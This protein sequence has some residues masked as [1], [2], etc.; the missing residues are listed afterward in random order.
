MICAPDH[1]KH[2]GPCP[3]TVAQLVDEP[4]VVGKL[5]LNGPGAAGDMRAP[6]ALDGT[7]ADTDG[8]R[9]HSSSPVGRLGGRISL[10]ERA[11]MAT[12]VPCTIDGRRSSPAAPEFLNSWTVVPLRRR[13]RREWLGEI[14]PRMVRGRPGSAGASPACAD[15]INLSVCGAPGHRPVASQRK[16]SSMTFAELS[17]YALSFSGLM[18]FSSTPALKGTID[19]I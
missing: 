2:R 13:S 3:T 16:S 18:K 15:C 12:V 9:H 8:F 17:V 4:R 19:A 5:E 1:A 6:D 10:G 7:R 11:I 14:A